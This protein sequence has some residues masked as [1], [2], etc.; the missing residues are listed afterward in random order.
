[1][2]MV[3]LFLAAIWATT[4]IGM[5]GVAR[6]D[7][8]PRDAAFLQALQEVGIT[9]PSADRVIASGKAVCSYMAGGHS[10]NATVQM[11]AEENPELSPD[12]AL[13]FVDLAR[14]AYCP[15][16]PMGGGGGG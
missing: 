1:M 10:P 9:Y 16:P 13:Q 14:G 8:D 6:A 11:V 7:D 15:L 5:A 2:N 3:K 4:L 12:Q